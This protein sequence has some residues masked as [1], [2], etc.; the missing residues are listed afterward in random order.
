MA[1]QNKVITANSILSQTNIRIPKLTTRGKCR[2]H[3]Y[4]TN[5]LPKISTKM[6]MNN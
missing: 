3:K 1:R 5:I 6:D 2:N 4:H